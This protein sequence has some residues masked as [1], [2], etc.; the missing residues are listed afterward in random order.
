MTV[1]A[2]CSLMSFVEVCCGAENFRG[3]QASAAFNL[4]ESITL[5]S[6]RATVSAGYR[7]TP[8]RYLGIGSG[9][10]WQQGSIPDSPEFPDLEKGVINSFPIFM[11][12]IRYFPFRK[13][14]RHT[15]LLG[16]EGGVTL[17]AEPIF[18]DETYKCTP[19]LL[20]KTG[21]D[22]TIFRRLGINFGF[23]AYAAHSLSGLGVFIGT[24]F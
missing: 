14:P 4:N 6:R 2:V 5:S 9:I 8:K 22:L 1:A 10:S 7:F 19:H 15:F 23:N 13:R 18:T 20:L 16:A 21:F 11:D 12:Y 17:F 24:R 3:F